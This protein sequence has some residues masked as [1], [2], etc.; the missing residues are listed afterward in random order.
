VVH[1]A[2]RTV[3]G[4][5][6]QACDLA[7]NLQHLSTGCIVISSTSAPGAAVVYTLVY[8]KVN[9]VQFIQSFTDFADSRGHSLHIFNVPYVPPQGA[10]HGSPETIVQVKVSATMTNHY[11]LPDVTTRFVVAR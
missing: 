11:A 7:T 8:P 4:G 2:P 10:K 3:K 1:N 6:T 5:N 9:G